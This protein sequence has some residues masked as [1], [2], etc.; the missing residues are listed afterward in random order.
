MTR[1][2]NAKIAGFTFLFYAA[3]GLALEALMHQ[4]RGVGSNAESLA[5]IGQYAINVR[6][7]ILI[8]LLEC[9]SALVLGVTLYGITR[10]EDHELA[11][12]GLACRVAEGLLGTLRIQG[13]LGLLWFAERGAA[14]PDVATTNALSAVLLMP[15][16]I[17]SISS[18]FYAVGNGI[19]LFFFLRGRMVPVLLAWLG[20][21]ASGMLVVLLPLQLAGFSTGLL[22]GY[23]QWLPALV[24]Q[25]ALA[26]WLLIKGV[27]TPAIR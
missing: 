26:L 10:E 17:V 14:A 7:S 19:F 8:V 27:A 1:D 22:S 20:V 15:S 5:R 11:T 2:T 4:A 12:L 23:Y 16:P 6:V 13:Y 21:L 3:I 9:F 25:I 24:F 18:I